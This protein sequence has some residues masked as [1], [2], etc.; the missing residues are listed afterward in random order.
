MCAPQPPAR[1]QH[2]ANPNSVNSQGRTPVWRAAFMDKKE[3]VEYLLSVGGD[4]RIP[5]DTQ[6][7][8]APRAHAADRGHPA[9]AKPC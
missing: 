2:G 6:A 8:R 1:S 3:C 5:S 7:R 9:D 4:P